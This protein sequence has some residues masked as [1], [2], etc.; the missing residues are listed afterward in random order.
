MTRGLPDYLNPDALVAQRMYD[1]STIMAATLG[2][3]PMD[4]K[5]RI[6]ALDNWSNGLSAWTGAL[7]GTG[8]A[9]VPKITHPETPPVSLYCVQ[10]STPPYSASGILRYFAVADV[11]RIGLEISVGFALQDPIIN[12][13]ILPYGTI[14]LSSFSMTINMLTGVVQANTPLGLVTV[15]TVTGAGIGLGFMPVKLVCDPLGHV[16][17]NL[18]VGQAVIDLSAYQPGNNLITDCYQYICAAYI[19]ANTAV[20]GEAYMGHVIVTH[21]EP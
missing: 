21:D 14:G 3:T 9:P 6:I 5:G 7:N 19:V 1:L 4:G 20:A 8:A 2:V 16:Y 13:Q 18:T 11:S 15:G 10:G 12:L 17:G